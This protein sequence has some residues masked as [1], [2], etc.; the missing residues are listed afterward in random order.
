MSEA[1]R[2][3]YGNKPCSEAFQI[4]FL[5]QGSIAI[6]CEWCHRT[7]FN[8]LSNDFETGELDEL[9]TK[10]EED[11]SSYISH[12]TDVRYGHFMGRQVVQGCPCGFDGYWEEIVWSERFCVRD[13]LLARRQQEV[14][15]LKR[16]CK[17]VD[18]IAKAVEDTKD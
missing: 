12:N 17:A 16:T 14:Q 1:E 2:P 5:R 7:H 4:A 3:K 6:D 10:E 13:Y 15:A 18:D 11:L 9:Q 8:S